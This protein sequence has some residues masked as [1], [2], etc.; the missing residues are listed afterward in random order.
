MHSID[1]LFG[2]VNVPSGVWIDESG[3]I[4]R[5]PETAWPGKSMFREVL[6]KMPPLGED[7]DPYIKK[8]LEQSAK[9]KVQPEAYLSALRDWANKGSHSRF[10]LTPDAVVERSR[11]LSTEHAEAAAHFELGQHLKGIG[12]EDA[13]IQHFKCAHVLDPDNWTYKRQ[14]WQYV[15]PVLQ[16]AAE[17]YGTTWADEVERVGPERYYAMPDLSH[18]VS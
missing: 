12:V 6:A 13:S 10:A 9:I 18:G 14:A 15:S 2:I 4:V 16:N 7:A 3:I 5:P 8:T 1:E 17:V 11:P